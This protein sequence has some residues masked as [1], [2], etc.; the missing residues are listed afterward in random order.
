MLSRSVLRNNLRQSSRSNLIR[1]NVTATQFVRGMASDGM[2]NNY[3]QSPIHVFFFFSIKSPES[4]SS[5]Y[6]YIKYSCLFAL[7]FFLF[8]IESFIFSQIFIFSLLLL[9]H[10][11]LIDFFNYPY[12][13]N[14]EK[15]KNF[16]NRQ[17]N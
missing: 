8:S 4:V 15:K 9:F 17:M 14:S 7:I 12:Y 10:F 6:I 11:Q 2:Y 16:E 3:F 1:L 5:S 13:L